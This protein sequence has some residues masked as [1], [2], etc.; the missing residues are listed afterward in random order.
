M[1]SIQRVTGKIM[2]VPGPIPGCIK[3]YPRIAGAALKRI[4]HSQGGS[5]LRRI[6]ENLLTMSSMKGEVADILA[7][8]IGYP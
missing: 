8:F 7:L 5:C 4:T 3:F 6:R 1:V 2:E